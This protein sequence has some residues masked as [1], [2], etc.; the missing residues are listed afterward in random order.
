MDLVRFPDQGAPQKFEIAVIVSAFTS[1]FLFLVITFFLVKIG[2][3]YA[4]TT[5]AKQ[6]GALRLLC[7]RLVFTALTCAW[8]CAVSATKKSVETCFYTASAGAFSIA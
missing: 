4:K 2:H 3:A 5:R 7:G 1:I 8:S 6:Q